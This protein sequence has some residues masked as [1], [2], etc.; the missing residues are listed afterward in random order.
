M[1][2]QDLIVQ[3]LSHMHQSDPCRQMKQDQKA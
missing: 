1:S 3:M 2:S